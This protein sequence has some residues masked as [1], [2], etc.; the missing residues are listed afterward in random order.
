METFEDDGVAPVVL[1]LAVSCRELPVSEAVEC[2]RL[3]W[4]VS[5]DVSDINQSIP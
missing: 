1:G 2:W 5:C 4:R 3:S